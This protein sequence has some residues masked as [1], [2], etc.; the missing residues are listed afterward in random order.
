MAKLKLNPVI[1]EITGRLGNLIFRRTHSGNVSLSKSP[2][3]SHVQWSPAQEA[4]RQRFKEAVE[5]A[6]SAMADPEIRQIYEQMAAEKKKNK[7]PFDMAVSDYFQ[8][9]D[10]LKKKSLGDQE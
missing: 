1:E 5:Y 6:R 2:N 4:H 9:N 3:M 7:R 8:G 10:L